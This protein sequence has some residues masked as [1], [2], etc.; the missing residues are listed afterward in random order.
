MK[1]QVQIL[2]LTNK[3]NSKILPVQ[4]Y[5][6]KSNLL[7]RQL[8]REVESK[9]SSGPAQDIALKKIAQK[10]KT[11]MGR[12]SSRA[13]PR[14][15]ANDLFQNSIFRNPSFRESDA[16]AE[17]PC[18]APRSSRTDLEPQ[19]PATLAGEL[20]ERNRWR[21]ENHIPLG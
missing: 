10:S 11:L 18:R 16:A 5:P 14:H 6:E 20:K 2:D 8:A 21:E 12:P 1:K 4:I 9:T 3:Y 7:S 15:P 19:G 13:S 17:Q